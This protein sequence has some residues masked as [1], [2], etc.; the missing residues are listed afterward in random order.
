MRKFLLFILLFVP[1]LI[2]AQQRVVIS[3]TDGSKLIIP[4]WKIDNI[5][6]QDSEKLEAPVP[7]SA[8]NLG[9]KSGILWS[10]WNIGAKSENEIGFLLGWGNPDS[11]NLSTDLKYFPTP[12][13]TS[14]I[15]NRE[16]DIAKYY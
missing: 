16:F 8:V 1:S 11:T 3:Q 10:P 5:S 14:N 13:A 12:T 4:V 15:T 7:G 9:L 6:F 2:S